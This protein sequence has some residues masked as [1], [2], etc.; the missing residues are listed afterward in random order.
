MVKDCEIM[1]V[2]I[3]RLSKEC[4]L[5]SHI[6]LKLSPLHVAHLNRW[7]PYMERNTSSLLI[8]RT[9]GRLMYYKGKFGN[10]LP[11]KKINFK[12]GGFTIQY[13]LEIPKF[14]CKIFNLQNKC[15]TCAFTPFFFVKCIR[16]VHNGHSEICS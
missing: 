6:E 7:K 15:Q 9:H 14:P 12:K 11:S 13:S 4:S 1:K 16:G 8:T 5:E 3:P 10:L 2:E